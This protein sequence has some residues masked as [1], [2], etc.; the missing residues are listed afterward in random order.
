[1]MKEEKPAC[2]DLEE[3]QRQLFRQFCCQ[4]VEDP[5]K[6]HS[7]LQELCCQWLKPETHSKEQILEL[8]ILEQF[9]ASL[10]PPDLQG[11]IRAGGP[12]SC[13]QAVALVEDFLMGQQEA[14]TEKWQVSLTPSS[15]LILG[16]PLL[17]LPS[18]VP[19][20][21]LFSRESFLLIRWPKYLIF[22]FNIPRRAPQINQGSVVTAELQEEGCESRGEQVGQPVKRE[23]EFNEFIEGLTTVLSQSSEGHRSDHMPMF[24]KYG[25][26]YCYRSELDMTVTTEDYSACPMSEGTMQQNLYSDKQGTATGEEKHEC[27]ESPKIFT[28]RQTL[29]SHQG[30][31]TGEKSYKC[32]MCGKSFRQSST[33][34]SHQRIHT[35]EKPY[36]CAECGKCFRESGKLKIHQRIHTGEKPHKCFQCGKSFRKSENLK[37]HQRIHTGEK[38]HKCSQCGKNFRQSENLKKHQRIHTGEKPYKCPQCGKWFSRSENLK[39]HQRIH[40]GEKPYKCPQCGK[41]FRRSENLKEHQRIHTG[42]KPYKCSQCGRCFRH[43]ATLMTHQ[44]I[45]TKKKQ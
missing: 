42:E 30:I 44:R 28:F 5:R 36:K 25:R 27:S 1:M 20:I 38:P 6:L 15:H 19:S 33:L 41:C 29:E 24:S 12:D 8:L 32:S 18:I 35:G 16:R 4:E 17:L 43:S 37:K 9:L 23:K 11:W 39:I 3:M 2:L 45:H 26:R 40:T 13:S 34:M 10:L 22:I 14:E 21:R 31:Y 7:Q